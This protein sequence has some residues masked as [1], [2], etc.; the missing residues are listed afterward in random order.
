MKKFDWLKAL[1]LLC[2]VGDVVITIVSNIIEAKKMD[3]KITEA[4]QAKLTELNKD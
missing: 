2:T 4:V 1:G 3:A